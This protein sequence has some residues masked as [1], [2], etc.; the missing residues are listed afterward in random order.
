M[1]FDFF[2]MN[3]SKVKVPHKRTV[4]PPPLYLL[5]YLVE[6]HPL[7][8]CGPPKVHGA[9]LMYTLPLHLNGKTHSL[10]LAGPATAVQLPAHLSCVQTAVPVEL[11]TQVLQSSVQVLPCT[12]SGCI[13]SAPGQLGG[14]R[15]YLPC[16]FMWVPLG[17]VAVEHQDLPR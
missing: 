15:P 8:W 13:A 12:Q 17:Y 7:P 3:G 5:T 4:Y 16:P 9:Q 11:H 6:H 14:H 2:R 1:A 10:P